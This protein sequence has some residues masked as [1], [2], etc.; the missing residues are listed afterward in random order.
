M[1]KAKKSLGQNFLNDT[2]VVHRI[3]EVAN[4]NSES[5]VLE[6]GPGMGAM[7]E[8]LSQIAK[9]I[10]AIE[11]D[12]RLY[13]YLTEKKQL[14]NTVIINEDFLKMTNIQ[15]AALTNNEELILV[16]NLPY[17]ITT[18]IITTVLLKYPQIKAI[19][20][21]VQKEVGERITAR[22]CT[23]AYGSLSV[24]CQTLADVEYNFT[25]SRESFT[26]QPKIDSSIITLKRKS[27]QNID[28]IKFEKLL[29]ISFKQKRKTLV[30]NLSDGL[31]ISKQECIEI[32]KDLS[33][34]ENIR[35]EEISVDNFHR[36]LLRM[37]LL[38]E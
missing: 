31:S 25:V 30:N 33:L 2:T 7:T 36:L 13:E 21:M 18:P 32:L 6:I 19:T 15:V 24:F 8:P 12:T 17:Y 38:L 20:I 23:K 37:N 26:P 27:I 28:I 3:I 16:A 4:V 29:K 11:I 14:A 9:Q 5:V 34:K 35:A 1:I 10:L 22:D